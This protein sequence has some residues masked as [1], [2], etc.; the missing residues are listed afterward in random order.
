MKTI[1]EKPVGADGGKVG[2][3]V[4]DGNLEVKIQY[5]VAKIVQPIKTALDPLKAKLEALIPGD[6]DN[7]LIDKAFDAAFDEIV[8]LLAE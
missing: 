8:K 7:P 6:W 3:Y 1:L 4:E 2:L 5:P